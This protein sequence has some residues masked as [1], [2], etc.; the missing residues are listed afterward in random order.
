MSRQGISK[1]T[2][3]GARA[4]FVYSKA[5]ELLARV[6]NPCWKR[7][8]ASLAGICH[9]MDCPYYTIA[10]QMPSSEIQRGATLR[11]SLPKKLLQ[12]VIWIWRHMDKR[13]ELKQIGHNCN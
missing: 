9:L 3:C 8:G 7:V 2:L 11:V 4:W 12:L 13:L 1:T 6:R 5:L 10:R